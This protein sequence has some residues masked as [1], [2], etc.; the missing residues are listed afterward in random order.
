[1][2]V[3]ERIPRQRYLDRVGVLP[4]AIKI[5]IFH[6]LRVCEARPYQAQTILIE[7]FESVA[8]RR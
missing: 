3:F 6:K 2:S 5:D 1:M 4:S 8:L 7:G